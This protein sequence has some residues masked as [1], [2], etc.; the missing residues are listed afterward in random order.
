M[1]DSW[2][3]EYRFWA[4]SVV[5]AAEG[6]GLSPIRNDLLHSLFFLSSALAPSYGETPMVGLVMKYRRGPYYPELDWHLARL[7]VQGFLSVSDYRVESDKAGSYVYA[8]YAM[9][10]SGAAF[11]TKLL[12]IEIWS[13]RFSFFRD[14]TSGFARLSH[15]RIGMAMTKDDTYASPGI[16]ERDITRFFEPETNRTVQRLSS[17]NDAL[18][19]GIG[20]SNQDLLRA[21][22]ALLNLRAA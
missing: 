9:T 16:A 8:K 21:Y 1:S 12:D 20:R 19:K 15:E 14:I 22:A 17:L 13:K 7:S 11:V 18:P 3:A 4:L 2:H 6:A 5:A 10:K